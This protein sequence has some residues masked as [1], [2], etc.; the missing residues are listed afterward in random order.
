MKKLLFI[1]TLA[2]IVCSC[3][4][5]EYELLQPE[6]SADL[7]L[8]A[9]NGLTKSDLKSFPYWARMG[10]GAPYGIPTD[11]EFG[12]ICFYVADPVKEI[13]ENFDLL[14]FVDY[15]ATLPGVEFAVEGYKWNQPDNWYPHHLHLKGKGAV[16]FWII[17]F[18]QVKLFVNDEGQRIGEVTIPALQALD[19]PPLIG[20]ASSFTENLRPFGGGAPVNGIQLTAQGQLVD[21]RKFN[22]S[23]HTKAKPGEELESKVILHIIE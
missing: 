15:R 23:Y 9:K 8:K 10:A 3:E 11:G 12:I 13:D 17:S 7:E 1:L 6:E 14:D 20:Y 19:P 18:E 2:L 16:P 22:Y 4:K 5:Q 21:G